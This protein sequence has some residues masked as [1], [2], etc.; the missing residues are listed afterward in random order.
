MDNYLRN[1]LKKCAALQPPP[2]DGKLRLLRVA[3]EPAYPGKVKS[4][5]RLLFPGT[6]PLENAQF[7]QMTSLD[8]L[9]STM[10]WAFRSGTLNLRFFF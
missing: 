6:H 3:A 10:I 2:A 1:S 9:D 5:L 8:F 4:L 7:E